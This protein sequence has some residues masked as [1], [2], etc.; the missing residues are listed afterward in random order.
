MS[1]M[2]V[3]S[4]FQNKSHHGYKTSVLKSGICKYMRRYEKE[5]FTWC[6]MEMA[7]FQKHEKGK[8]LVTNLINRLKILIME[9]LCI[10]DVGTFTIYP[11]SV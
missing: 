1:Q 7:Y 5:K 3:H 11:Y 6:V 4:C 8:A 10:R 9:E 2:I